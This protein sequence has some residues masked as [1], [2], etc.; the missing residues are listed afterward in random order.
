MIKFIE[1]IAS[2]ALFWPSLIC[3][4]STFPVNSACQ[5]ACGQTITYSWAR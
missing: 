2:V 3:S 5:V 4:G 1:S